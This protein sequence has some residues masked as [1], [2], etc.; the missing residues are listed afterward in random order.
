M[1][2]T[3]QLVHKA[4]CTKGYLTKQT[5]W[6]RFNIYT[7]HPCHHPF[8]GFVSHSNVRD[9]ACRTHWWHLFRA[10]RDINSIGISIRDTPCH[11]GHYQW[12]QQRWICSR[13]VWQW[14]VANSFC[15]WNPKVPSSGQLAWK[16]RASCC[17]SLW[18]LFAIWVSLSLSCVG[19]LLGKIQFLVKLTYTPSEIKYKKNFN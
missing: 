6:R 17:L 19:W 1:H 4:K 11:V 14:K 8:A 15:F 3:F 7:M 13:T 9:C 2:S 12:K 16:G 5:L 18:V 10:R